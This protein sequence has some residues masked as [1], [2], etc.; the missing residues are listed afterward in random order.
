MR[1]AETV[2]RN[3]KTYTP[4]P[5][6]ALCIPLHLHTGMILWARI[7]IDIIIQKESSIF[8][9]YVRCHII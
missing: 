5:Q 2:T 6:H 1:A 9:V 7:T 3:N 8:Y 4:G